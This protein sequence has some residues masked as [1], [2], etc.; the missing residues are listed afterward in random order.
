MI[1]IKKKNL[2]L[3]KFCCKIYAQLPVTA[4]I[5]DYSGIQ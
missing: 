1:F 3:R 4:L 5:G 2:A